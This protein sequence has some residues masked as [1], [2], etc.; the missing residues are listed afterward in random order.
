MTPNGESRLKASM[1]IWMTS[2]E[3]TRG[4][5]PAYSR[6]QIADAAIAIADARG[7]S[8]VTM[9]TVAAEL[10]TG[11]MSLYRYVVNKDGLFV[12]MGDR[13]LG[14]E[15][16]PE[17]T[18]DWRKDLRDFARGQRKTLLTHPW[19]LRVWSGQL[20]VGPNM[21]RGFERTISIMDGLGLDIDQMVEIPMLLGTWVHGYVQDELDMKA[22][23]GNTSGAEV[24][25][26]MDSYI[27]SVVSSGEYPYFSRFLHRARK[28]HVDDEERF[29]RALDRI[30]AGI[31]ATLPDYLGS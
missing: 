7:L 10:G 21:L 13:I 2:T 27:D 31:E 1:Q 6:D 20:V 25:K 11:A 8:A 30:L 17:L 16:W 18:G 28:S 19:L 26:V 9:R 3:P 14:R 5:V 15:E 12:L 29:E 23:F 4:P 24:Q 22:S